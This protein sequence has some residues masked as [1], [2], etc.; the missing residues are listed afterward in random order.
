ML[1]T[2][3][4]AKPTL[5]SAADDLQRV[6]QAGLMEASKVAFCDSDF[7]LRDETRGI[8]L[9]LELL[10]AEVGQQLAKVYSTLVLFGGARVRSPVTAQAALDNATQ[11]GCPLQ[12]KAAEALVR[13][14]KYYEYAEELGRLVGMHG[15]ATKDPTKRLT[16]ATGGGPGVM[17]AANKGA[18]EVGAKNMGFSILLPFEPKSNEYVTPELDF[19]FHYFSIRK[20]HFLLRAKAIVV[21]PGGFGT[22]DELFEVLTLIQCLKMKPIPIYLVGSDYWKN[23]IDWSLLKNEGFISPADLNIFKFSDSVTDIWLD[24]KNSYNLD[25]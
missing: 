22:L 24:L 12:I 15:V 9:Q 23:L 6:P 13:N 2:L 11:V 25:F 7:L 3:D 17:E 19:K 20:M 5:I 4:L 1:T 21:F 14:S 18:Q 16:L 8:R 10:K